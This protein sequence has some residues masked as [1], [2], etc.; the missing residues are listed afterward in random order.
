MKLKKLE[1]LGF[2]S[3][4]DKTLFNFSDGISAIVGPNGC[5]KSNVVDAIRWVMGEQ[6][7]KT[8]RGKKME[9]VIFNGSDDA[10]PVGLAEVSIILEKDGRTFPGQYAD[11][12]EVMISRKIFREGESEYQINK[13]PCRLLDVREFFMDSGVGARTYSI[14]EQESISRLI[15]AKPED[16]RE[17][18]EEAAGIKKYK[19]RRE[20]ATRKMESTRQNIARLKDITSEVKTQMNSMS[21]QAKRAERYKALRKNIKETEL[22][23][24]LQA[25]LDLTSRTEILKNS[26]ESLNEKSIQIKTNLQSLEALIEDVKSEL[27][28]NEGTIANLQEKFY[29]AKNKIN[30]DEQKIEFFKGKIEDIKARKERNLSEIETFRERKESME[31]ELSALRIL[32]AEADTK[33]EDVKNS[34]SI[35]Q[36]GVD[37]LKNTEAIL[38]GELEQ[39]KAGNFHIVTEHARLRNMLATLT[40]G[41]EDLKKKIGRETKDLNENSEKLKSVKNTLAALKSGLESDVE[42]IEVLREN[43]NIIQGKIEESRNNLEA[44]DE[45]VA[46]LKEETGIKTSRLASLKEFQEGYEWCNEGTKSILK[47]NREGDL[48]VDGIYGLVADHI[49]VPKEYEAAVEAVLGEKLQYVV[50]KSQEDGIEAI[51]YLK[52]HSS[53][54]GH[55][56]PLR[57]RNHFTNSSSSDHIEGIV[58]LDTFVRT[59]EDFKSIVDF[60]LG[61]VLL[62]TDLHTGVNLWRQNGFVGTFVT[63]EGDVISPH[64]ILTGGSGINGGS[65][66]LRNKREISELERE[67]DQLATPLENEIEIKN[68]TSALISQLSNE[69][70]ELRSDI[71]EAELN[72]N[73]KKKDAERSEG[74]IKWIEQRINVL[75]FNKEGLESEETEATEKTN[76]I[77]KEIVLYESKEREANESISALQEKWNKVK[78]DLEE[79]EKNLTE[80]KILL[81]SLEEKINSNAGAQTRLN[82]AISDITDE[83]ESN[84]HDAENSEIEVAQI[85]KN[86]NEEEENLQTLYKDHETIECEL[87]KKRELHGEKEMVLKEKEAE[88]RET[89]GTLENLTKDLNKLEMEIQELT[90]HIDTLKKGAYEK[91]HA[92][93]DMLLPNFN[94]LDEIA[95]KEL[96][97]KLEQDR[98]RIDDFGEVNLLALS[99]YEELKE[100]YDFLTTQIEDLNASLDT[101]Q[102]TITR[103]NRVSKKRFSETF[104]EINRCFGRVFPR[105]FPGGKGE[106][107]LTDESNML[108]TGVDIDIQIP[109]K[110][111]QN[112]SL[113]SGGEKALSAVALIFS[114]LIYKPSP[115]LILDE[116]DAALDDSNVELFKKLVREISENSQIIFITHNKRSMEVA[117]NLYGI[118]MEKHGITSSIAVNLN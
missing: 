108:E 49:D 31:K 102:K 69:L 1:I 100:R 91:F 114:I 82:N 28:E 88:T 17:F 3:F 4:K 8:L 7:V 5:G 57:V 86:V 13:V 21:R 76:H 29:N 37:H 90:L 115:F 111:R 32:I 61:D 117:D 68:E 66:L 27:L 81:T 75:T 45:N 10:A 95:A 87:A 24:S 92:D 60:L 18:I 39:G 23:L 30:M 63:P 112:I 46:Q 34:I 9:D 74:E 12:S 67:I 56:V 110:K 65:S 50:V 54:R 79:R 109:G 72:A 20:S 99:E 94:K 104:I 22:T 41:I 48:P 105:L 40:R 6:R 19:S 2:K 77:E 116:V 55:F 51:D 52:K 14:V 97:T 103:M 106:L 53:G 11:C 26:R 98:K 36:E 47:A 78:T 101:L 62:I 118:T 25:Y 33:I 71:H 42:K 16:I 89:K 96:R 113:L 85:R 38:A 43:E 70:D 73:S 107:R 35:S 80:E 64:G 58:K 15:E 83:I 93:L 59:K 84:I 44:I